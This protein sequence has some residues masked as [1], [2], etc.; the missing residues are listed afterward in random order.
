MR[1]FRI[2]LGRDRGRARRRT[3][4]CA[5]RWCRAA[6]TGPGDQRLVAYVVRRGRAPHADGLRG[7]LRARLA[8]PST[9]SRP[10]SSSLAGLPL[11]ANGKVDRQALPA[12]ERGAGASRGRP[13]SPPRT[14]LERRDRRGLA[15]GAGRRAGG[16]PRQLLRPGRPLPAAGPRSTA[17][18]QRALGR[19]RPAR[20]PLPPPDGAARS[21]A[22]PARAGRRRRGGR[23][24]AP[25]R[26]AASVAGTGGPRARTP[27]RSPSSAWPAASPARRTVEAFWA[28]LRA[29]RRVDHASSP[30]RSC[31]R[32]GVDPGARS[33]GPGYV[34]AR[35]V[36]DGVDRFDA[37]FFGYHPA[38][39]R[40]H[41]PAA[42]PLPG[43]RLGGAGATPA[44][45]PGRSAGPDRRLRRRGHEHL[46]AA[47]LLRQPGGSRP[48][49]ACQVLLGNDKDFLATRVS[50]K[51]EPA[52][53]R[54]SPC[55]PPARPRWSPSTS[56]ARACSTASATWRWPAASSI[57]VPA[58]RRLPLPG[59][60]HPL[61]RRPLPRLRR[62]GPGHGRR[63]R[64][65]GRGAQ[66][67]G[68][69]PGRRRPHPRRDPG[70]AINN[71]GAG[72][73]RL[74]RPERRR[75]GRGHRR[76]PWPLAGVDPETI[77]YVEAHG[78]GTPLGDPIEVAALTQ[79]FRAADAAEQRLLRPRLGQDQRRPPRRGRRRRRPDQDR[80]SPWSTGRSR[81]ACTSRR[82]TRRSTSRR[83]RSTST[84]ALR[85]VAGGRRA[86]PGRR[87]LL[88]HRRHQRPRR[89]GGGAGAGQPSGPAPALAAPRRSRPAPPTA[90]EA[91]TAR[92]AAH[93]RR[94]PGRARHLA[95]V[96]YTLQVGRKALRAPPRRGLPRRRGRPG[97]PAR[98]ATAGGVLGGRVSGAPAPA[99]RS[100]SSSPARAT[101]YP[102]M[103]R[104]L[105]RR[106]PVFRERS[107]AAPSSSPARSAL[108]LRDAALPGRQP[109][110]AGTDSGRAAA[111]L[112]A[113]R[114][115]GPLDRTARPSRLL[116]RRVRA[117]PA[118][119][120]AWGVAPAGAC[121]AT[122]SASTWPPAWPAS[123]R[124]RTP[125]GLVRR[126]RPA[127][128]GP[129]PRRDARRPAA[130]GR[131]RCRCSAGGL[132]L[133]ASTG[134]ALPWSA[135]PAEAV[136]ALERDL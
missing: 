15:R 29:R 131:G 61:A 113:G 103:A 104:G 26:A 52:R 122:A 98:A 37:A 115:R 100:P 33:R 47:N 95:D 16:R 116:R 132:S 7:A 25:R 121:S 42:A 57:R 97:R 24:R 64:R 45:T 110:S 70:S 46:P 106:E 67:A 73:G 35:G 41:G 125:L 30:T 84:P 87:Q 51:L 19:E 81:P 13:T 99:G 20:R 63:Q 8:C 49:A 91:A 78:T 128:A 32:A 62:P 40:A 43:V 86:A 31:A 118:C 120:I 53:A 111:V 22:L 69:R 77:G 129:A 126:A 75:P 18:L 82:P 54:A 28:N 134:P 85:A 107:T 102:G 108:D 109:A 94:A 50:Y 112:D 66:A 96:A 4:R 23:P 127:D 44:T 114:R 17:R 71:D 133:A 2:E 80:R 117:G 14:E 101:Q 11:T 5:R 90:L 88:R 55:R 136:D 135:G 38:R 9:W 89:P 56:P 79:A 93:L 48:S 36:L 119:C 124:W 74:H 3:R 27:R 6:R 72:Q 60:R 39:G 105:Y 10:P 92:L 1:G 68:R 58:A 12:P 123:S 34:R 76:A 83:A 130:R 21:P 59:G 65:R